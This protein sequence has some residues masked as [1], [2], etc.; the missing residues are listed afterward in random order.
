M[1]PIACLA[2]VV[3][4]ALAS[5]GGRAGASGVVGCGALE[6]RAAL[7]AYVLAFNRGNTSDLQALIAAE[8]AFTWYSVAPPHGRTGEKAY[9]RVTLGTYL[10][11]RHASREVLRIVVF[12][13]ASTQERDGALTANING[14]LTRQASDLRS[15]RR[16]FKA[17]LRC[18]DR[19]ELIVL[20]IGTRI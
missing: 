2:A 5:T 17:T 8:P 13:F 20:S 12:N 1:R 14:E 16:G 4:L 11:A 6:A 3:A 7:N 9:D 18:G 10:R 15:E 19:L